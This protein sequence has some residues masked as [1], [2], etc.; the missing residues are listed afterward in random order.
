MIILT[1]TIG[2]VVEQS[3]ELSLRIL[4]LKNAVGVGS[5]VLQ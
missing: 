2:T 3:V 4:P 1:I 5:T